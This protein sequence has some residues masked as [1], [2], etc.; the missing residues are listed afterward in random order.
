M[1]ITFEN[2]FTKQKNLIEIFPLLIVINKRHSGHFSLIFVVMRF[3]FVSLLLTFFSSTPLSN[4]LY[5]KLRFS[6][7]EAR[8]TSSVVFVFYRFLCTPSNLLLFP[9]CFQFL[10]LFFSFSLLFL[11]CTFPTFPFPLFSFSSAF[12]LVFVFELH[13]GFL[14]LTFFSF[15]RITYVTKKPT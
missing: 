4:F 7:T 2:R 1:L 10:S 12:F 11:L 9:Q 3:Y 6:Y 14:P 13:P 15:P 8:I 5:R